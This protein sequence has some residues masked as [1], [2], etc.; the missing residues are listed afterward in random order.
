MGRVARLS[1]AA[2]QIRAGSRMLVRE[3]K[4]LV[5]E[6]EHLDLERLARAA[7]AL[8]AGLR[9]GSAGPLE[10]A[11]DQALAPVLA[12]PGHRPR[13]RPLPR[14]GLLLLAALGIGAL[15]LLAVV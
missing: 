11:V 3:V 2:A 5:P 12:G 9:S 6:T 13:P 15:L 7:A 1:E 14:G 4:I 8:E 10:A